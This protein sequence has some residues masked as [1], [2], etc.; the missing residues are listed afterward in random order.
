MKFLEEADLNE[1]NDSVTDNFLW[2]GR[3]VGQT[4]YTVTRKEWVVCETHIL[5]SFP[6]RF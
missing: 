5:G 6:D 2:R 4:L 3:L 1:N